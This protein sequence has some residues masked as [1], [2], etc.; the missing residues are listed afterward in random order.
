MTPPRRI[1]P[2]L[3]GAV[4]FAAGSCA[5]AQQPVDATKATGAQSASTSASSGS[6]SAVPLAAAVA[7]ASADPSPDV[8]KKA[9]N[10]GYKPEHHNGTTLFCKSVSEIGSRFPTKQCIDEN[11]LDAV[12]EKQRQQQDL[13]S[14]K[15][16][17]GNCGGR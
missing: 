15:P 6:S 2:T 13:M 9:R 5:L 7:N 12:I 10:L 16:C 17:G 4:L 3:V 1:V 14:A 8:L 11:S